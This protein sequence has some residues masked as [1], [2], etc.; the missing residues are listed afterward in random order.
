M[1]IED[2]KFTEKLSEKKENDSEKI[3]SQYKKLFNEKLSEKTEIVT[4]EKINELKKR[5]N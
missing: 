5:N 4:K 2:A 3:I 1:I